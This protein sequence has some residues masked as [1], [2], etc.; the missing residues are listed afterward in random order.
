MATLTGPKDF[1][2]RGWRVVMTARAGSPAPFGAFIIP[3]DGKH[4]ALGSHFAKEE[5]ARDAAKEEID[6]RVGAQPAELVG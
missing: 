1:E 5:N 6:R 4:E 2:H 3:P